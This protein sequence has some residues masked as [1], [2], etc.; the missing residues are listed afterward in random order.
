MRILTR[1]VLFELLK[2]FL[3][4]L[5]GITMF[6]LLVGVGREAY[7]QGL[8]LKQIILLIPYILPDMLTFSIPGT[9]LF[10]ACSVYGRMASS[11]EVVA[12]KAQGISPMVLLWPTIVFAFLLSLAAVWLN[13]VA[14]S[15]GREGAKRLV[16]SSVVEIIYSKLEQQHCY[17]ARQISIN[18]KG[19]DGRTLLQPIF[20]LGSSD[21]SPPVTISCQD[22]VLSSDLAA[23]TLTLICHNGTIDIGGSRFT[24]PDTLPRVIP[25]DEASKKGAAVRRPTS[26]STRSKPRSACKRNGSNRP[27]SGW[28]KPARMKCSP[29]TSRASPAANGPKTSGI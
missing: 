18:V 20:S 22:A 13:D 5:T 17:S 6:M 21:D 10:A 12:V 19:L 26:S 3:V 7:L 27:N 15:W 4:A 2:V 1:Y 24:F 14:H 25:L 11:N 29:A 9:I 23:N 16:I 28:P 8:G